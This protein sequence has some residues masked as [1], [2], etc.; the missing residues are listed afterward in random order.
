MS[1][2][3]LPLTHVT[4]VATMGDMHIRVPA[5]TYRFGVTVPGRMKCSMGWA[6]H[7]TDDGGGRDG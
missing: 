7:L 2:V 6:A 1:E 5:G 3:F 4:T